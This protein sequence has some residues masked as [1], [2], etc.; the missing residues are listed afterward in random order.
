MPEKPGRFKCSAK[1]IQIATPDQQVNAGWQGP[2]LCSNYAALWR[3]KFPPTNVHFSQFVLRAQDELHP[4]VA[5]TIEFALETSRVTKGFGKGRRGNAEEAS[6]SSDSVPRLALPAI[7]SYSTPQGRSKLGSVLRAFSCWNPV[8]GYN[9]IMAA[10]AARIMAVTGS[11]KLT[12]Q[13]LVSIYKKYRLKDYF[14]GTFATQDEH[15]MNDAEEVW[16][17]IQFEWPD[18]AFIF[19]QH[20]HGEEIFKSCIRSLL[21]TVLTRTYR[22]EMQPFEW[23]VRLLHHILLPVGEYSPRD[24][25][26]QLR[27]IVTQIMARH[28]QN[29]RQC[30]DEQELAQAAENVTEHVHVDVLLIKLLAKAPT[31]LTTHMLPSLLG[32]LFGGSAIGSLSYEIA[33]HFLPSLGPPVQI[34]LGLSAAAAGTLGSSRVAAQLSIER[35]ADENRELL[36]VGDTKDDEAEFDIFDSCIVF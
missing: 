1:S 13:I 11:E 22:A 17:S 3:E 14:E 30:S 10:L 28:L 4:D 6:R 25:R 9:P 18:L 2:R 19:R 12:F 31:S 20:D 36:F 24:P 8:V 34:L 7:P 27:H 32:G 29:F 21:S 5:K 33:S 15:L 23:H 26:A 16:Q 35:V